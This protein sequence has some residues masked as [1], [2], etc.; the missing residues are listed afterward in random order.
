MCVE[1]SSPLPLE[2]ARCTPVTSSPT[3]WR[4]LFRAHG[5]TGP[6]TWPCALDS[7]A[8]ACSLISMT[9]KELFK[10]FL[11]WLRGNESD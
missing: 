2:P 6:A 10:E 8:L 4:A 3:A 9:F 1:A 11:L 7:V 5:H